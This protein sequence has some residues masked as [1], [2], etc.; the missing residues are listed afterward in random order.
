M[1]KRFIPISKEEERSH[2]LYRLRM[3]Y[4]IEDKVRKTR[5]ICPYCGN[6]QGK[7]FCIDG[8]DQYRCECCG[9]EKGIDEVFDHIIATDLFYKVL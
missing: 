1:S 3:K 7:F 9:I 8:E 5:G 2:I 6:N 4:V